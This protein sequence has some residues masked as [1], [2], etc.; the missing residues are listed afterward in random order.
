MCSFFCGSRAIPPIPP[1]A[2]TS[3]RTY[4]VAL[5]FLP[6][7]CLSSLTPCWLLCEFVFLLVVPLAF[8]T[9]DSLPM[10]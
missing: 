2:S 1:P 6:C 8:D 3:L 10:L 9:E 4:H 5:F 7:L